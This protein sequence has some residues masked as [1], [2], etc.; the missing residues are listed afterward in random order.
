MVWHVVRL[1]RLQRRAGRRPIRRGLAA[2]G[3]R[4]QAATERRRRRQL[5]TTE[6]QRGRG[7]A[8]ATGR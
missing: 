6:G 2:S 7:R 3:G 4:R 5:G 8:A 1:G